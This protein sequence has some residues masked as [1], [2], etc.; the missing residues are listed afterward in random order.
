MGYS[1]FKNGS[2]DWFTIS[3]LQLL[4]AYLD[5]FCGLANRGE[6]GGK[7]GGGDYELCEGIR[8]IWRTFFLSRT[9]NHV[10]TEREKKIFVTSGAAAI[11]CSNRYL[12]VRERKWEKGYCL[13]HWCYRD[14]NPHLVFVCVCVCER[15]RGNERERARERA[16]KREREYHLYYYSIIFDIQPCPVFVCVWERLRE[17]EQVPSIL[18]ALQRYQANRE[19]ERE[20]ERMYSICNWHYF[21]KERK[22]TVFAIGKVQTCNWN[23]CGSISQRYRTI[24]VVNV[25]VCVWERGRYCETLCTFFGAPAILSHTYWLH[26]IL[27]GATHRNTLQHTAT[28]CNTHDK[29]VTVFGAPAIWSHT[30][31]YVC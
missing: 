26:N 28:H 23:W 31:Q 3:S 14:M 15:E 4:G 1:Q 22:S 9:L 24:P 20:T 11:W 25:R 30:H 8:R 13:Y 17:R 19:K 6:R 18:L 2:L 21:E 16:R 7:G 10:K 12:R 27:C 29:L 5:H